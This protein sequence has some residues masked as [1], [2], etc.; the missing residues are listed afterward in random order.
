MKVHIPR[1][2][3]KEERA[4]LADCIERGAADAKISD[5]RGAVFLAGFLER[6]ADL[7]SMGKVVPLYNVVKVGASLEERLSRLA[8]YNRGFPYCVPRFVAGRA[9]RRQVKATAPISKVAKAT[10][11]NFARNSTRHPQGG[12]QDRVFD[13]MRRIKESIRAQMQ[14]D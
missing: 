3:S 14:E 9:L 13:D 4:A 11:D 6:M 10:L 7:V 8:R 12:A 1:L 5:D 2:L